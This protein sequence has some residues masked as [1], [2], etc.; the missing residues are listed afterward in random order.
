MGKVFSC[1]HNS[2]GNSSDPWRQTPHANLYSVTNVDREGRGTVKGT[3][4]LREDALCFHG[5][6]QEPINWELRVLRRFAYNNDIFSFE[7]G[8]RAVTGAACYAFKCSQAEDLFQKVQQ[9]VRDSS[10]QLNARDPQ[11]PIPAAHTENV[12]TGTPNTP[13]SLVNEDP[14][15]LTPQLTPSQQRRQSADSDSRQRHYV[16]VSPGENPAAASTC[17]ADPLAQRVGGG[18]IS[19]G[20]PLANRRTNVPSELRLP[21]QHPSPSSTI[22]NNQSSSAAGGVVGNGPS[23]SPGLAAYTGTEYVEIQ[24]PSAPADAPIQNFSP[25]SSSQGGPGASPHVTYSVVDF[26]KTNALGQARNAAAN[27]C[28][29]ATVN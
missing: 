15:P 10:L 5:R 28:F 8:R 27:S 6:G 16:N 12:Y 26:D 7:A 29:V 2:S 25:P 23:A 4:E 21:G 19:N 22:N 9:H 14:H 20:L 1:I 13:S 18:Y 11:L 3:L 17:Q 24:I